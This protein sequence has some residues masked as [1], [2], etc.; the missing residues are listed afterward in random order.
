MGPGLAPRE[1]LGPPAMGLQSC[2]MCLPWPPGNRHSH[3]EA[4]CH[5]QLSVHPGHLSRQ[6]EGAGT[7]LS[8]PVGSVRTTGRNRGPYRDKPVHRADGK[9][10]K[11][12]SSCQNITPKA[13]R[14]AGRTR[15]AHQETA[16]ACS[17]TFPGLPVKPTPPLLSPDFSTKHNVLRGWQ[18]GW[19]G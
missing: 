12:C 14:G 4:G 16:N 17:P 11:K 9:S 8:H 19:P 5:P 3:P 15:N 1:T 2:P 18:G 13:E 6:S 7:S 10:M